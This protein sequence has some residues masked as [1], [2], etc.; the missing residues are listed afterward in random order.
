MLR[1]RD[2][3]TCEASPDFGRNKYYA[4]RG[5]TSSRTHAKFTERCRPIGPDRRQ[6][7]VRFPSNAAWMLGRRLFETRKGPSRTRQPDKRPRCGRVTLWCACGR[8]AL[9]RP[10]TRTTARPQGSRPALLA[11]RRRSE[12]V[13]LGSDGWVRGRAVTERVSGALSDEFGPVIRSLRRDEILMDE[14]KT[15]CKKTYFFHSYSKTC[16]SFHDRR[17]LLENALRR[18]ICVRFLFVYRS[19][20][21][22]DWILR[23]VYNLFS[24]VRG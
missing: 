6:R 10:I 20:I 2:P 8:S 12:P 4:R 21:Y 9:A 13:G 18:S 3:S 19:T 16:F 11:V 7:P 15:V 23:S 5:T 1:K 14:T 17:L 24:I 22:Y